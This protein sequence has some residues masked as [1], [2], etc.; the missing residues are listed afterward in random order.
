MEPCA[1]S[2]ADMASLHMEFQ[3]CHLLDLPFPTKRKDLPEV[4]RFDVTDCINQCLSMTSTSLAL[5]VALVPAQVKQDTKK[6]WRT[7]NLCFAKHRHSSVL[8]PASRFVLHTGAILHA[9]MEM[10]ALSSQ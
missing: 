9:V 3:V 4:C 10:L 7:R 6:L 8:K 5:C 1:L 2:Q